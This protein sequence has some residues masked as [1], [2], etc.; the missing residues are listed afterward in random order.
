METEAA[1]FAENHKPNHEKTRAP[2]TTVSGLLFWPKY[3]F[4]QGV[5]LE[6]PHFQQQRSAREVQALLSVHPEIELSI[7]GHLRGMDGAGSSLDLPEFQKSLT[8]PGAKK[9]SELPSTPTIASAFKTTIRFELSSDPEVIEYV[10][11]DYGITRDNPHRV[12]G[13]V[14]LDERGNTSQVNGPAFIF[15]NIFG[16][17]GIKITCDEISPLALAGGMES[18]NVFNVSLIAAASMLSGANLSMA[19]IFSL[20]VKL[21]N[22]EFNGLTGGQ[23]HLCCMV[24]GAYRH[25][26]LSGLKYPEGNISNP[27]GAFSIQFLSDQEL[28]FLEEHLAL[29]Q[30]GKSYEGG[31]P[32]VCRTASLIN[33]MWTDLLRDQDRIGLPLHQE[34]LGLVERFTLALQKR[35]LQR[36]V[37]ALIRYVEIR[38]ALCI[39]WINLALDAYERKT[40]SYD[41]CALP[42]YASE[43]AKVFDEDNPRYSGCDVIREQFVKDKDSLRKVS[44][45]TFGPI[46]ELVKE[47]KGVGIAIMPLGAGGPGANLIAL[48]EKGRA[49]LEAF[50]QTKNYPPLTEERARSVIRGTG[51]LKGYMPFM[52]GKDPLSIQGFS[53][54]G[55]K[56]PVSPECFLYNQETGEFVPDK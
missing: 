19:D 15:Q 46:S 20:A 34:K 7:S 6:I 16:L 27:Y 33:W 44:F 45:Y 49:H 43:Y 17:A 30:A 50:L 38:D 47:A 31:R 3:S 9:L 10:A 40:V 32:R 12:K 21:E 25:V 8:R 48:S 26:W 14:T 2:T 41:G 23:G 11:P 18:S 52:A 42:S 51:L 37:A 39:R 28:D 56:L 53:K 5:P 1:R 4:T 22:D 24:G 36:A 29:V 54:L 35:D 55:L 13:Y